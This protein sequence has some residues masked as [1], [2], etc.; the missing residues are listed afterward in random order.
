[1]PRLDQ[2]RCSSVIKRVVE[3]Q[4]YRRSPRQRDV[5]GRPRPTESQPTEVHKEFA[6]D[7]PFGE[8][9]ALRK[10]RLLHQV[11]L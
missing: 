11:I 1:M 7:T 4:R 9:H 6:R 10:E 3:S 5:E 8:A 2:L